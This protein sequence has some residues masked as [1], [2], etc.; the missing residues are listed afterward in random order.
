MSKV[1]IIL[2]LQSAIYYD[3]LAWTVPS[4]HGSIILQDLQHCWHSVTCQT[5][6]QVQFEQACKAEE[7]ICTNLLQTSRLNFLSNLLEG[8]AHADGSSFLLAHPHPTSSCLS[9]AMCREDAAHILYPSQLPQSVLLFKHFL[10]N[11]MAQVRRKDWP[12]HWNVL[13]RL[14]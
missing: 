11:W 7:T 9:S 13:E 8:N 1:N 2:W 3:L 14:F 6:S 5:L 10:Q 4:I 12:L